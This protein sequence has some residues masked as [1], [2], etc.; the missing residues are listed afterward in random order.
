M[1]KRSKIILLGESRKG[2]K[3]CPGL[4]WPSVYSGQ[5]TLLHL[6]AGHPRHT[7]A[8]KR[9]V[10][11]LQLRGH[12]FWADGCSGIPTNGARY[13]RYTPRA[14]LLFCVC[15]YVAAYVPMWDLCAHVMH[16]P[17]RGRLWV[18]RPQEWPPCI[19]R[20]CHFLEP[21]AP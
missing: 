21:G 1:A 16:E 9:A 11:V 2:V 18:L 12:G 5:L 6:S 3:S 13:L 15:L 7:P 10:C 14:A 8:G 20:Q 19:L 4:A 17:V